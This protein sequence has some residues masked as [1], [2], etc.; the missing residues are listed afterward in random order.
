MYV[1]VLKTKTQ[2]KGLK[3][4]FLDLTVLIFIKSQGVNQA[5]TTPPGP[6]CFNIFFQA[7]V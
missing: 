4:Q 1:V 3:Y 7:G 2:K 6:P 5:V